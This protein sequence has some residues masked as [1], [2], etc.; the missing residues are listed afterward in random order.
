MAILSKEEVNSFIRYASEQLEN[1][2][3]LYE[4]SIIRSV[5]Q[6]SE[7]RGVELSTLKS[8]IYSQFWM[9]ANIPQLQSDKA[10]M[11]SHH[12]KVMSEKMEYYNKINNFEGAY[13]WV[14][15]LFKNIGFTEYDADK[16][17]LVIKKIGAKL[18][19]KANV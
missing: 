5:E 17:I 3:I 10:S 9:L 18:Y 6:I 7:E 4:S 11:K 8:H 16:L 2:R 15:T 13:I 14:S 19:H 1:E 12:E